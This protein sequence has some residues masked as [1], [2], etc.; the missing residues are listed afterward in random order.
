MNRADTSLTEKV[1]TGVAGLDAILG[2]G[3]PRNRLYLIQGE[4]GTG[5]TTLSLQFLLAGAR[6]GESGLYVSLSESREELYAVARS[7]GWSLDPISIFEVRAGDDPLRPE[8]E[9]TAFHPSEVEL[10][11]TVRTL[12]NEMERLKPARVVID[13]LSEMRLLARDPLRYRRQLVALKDFLMARGSTVLFLDDPFSKLGEDQFKTLASGVLRLE[14]LASDYGRER[15]RL[16]VLKLRG[17]EY[18]G[19]YHDF[20]INRGSVVVYPCLVAADHRQPPTFEKVPSGVAEVDALLGGGPERGTNTLV[21][22]PAGVGKSSLCLQYALAAARRGERTAIFLFDETAEIYQ[23]RTAALGLDVRRFLEGGQVLLRQIDPGTISPGEFIHDVRHAVEQN[24]ARVVVIDS[25][26]GYLNAMPGE[27]FL[28]IQMHE[29]L[30]YLD[31]RCVLSF[32]VIAQ[33]GLVG[34]GMQAPIDLSYLADTVLL[35]RYFEH[36]GKVR[37]AISVLKKRIGPHEDSIRELQISSDGVRVGPP[38]SQF[39][40]VLAGVPSYLGTANPLLDAGGDRRDG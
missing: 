24:G 38:L 13:S 36:A 1:S 40:G 31:L 26:N 14:R 35:L 3:L 27:Q 32:V 8:E 30:T 33:H 28:I 10:G 6:A 37:K 25:L 23:A 22:G 7:H 34:G 15:R 21:V 17:V 39:Q 19:G 20:R 5:K 9:Y 16:Q 2:G 11:E 29:L 18:H 4:P 12:L